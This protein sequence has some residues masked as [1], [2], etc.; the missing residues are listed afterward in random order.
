MTSNRWAKNVTMRLVRPR[1]LF[2]L[3]STNGDPIKKG[4]MKKARAEI[5]PSAAMEKRMS[6]FK[7]APL[8]KGFD[9]VFC[10]ITY[11]LSSLSCLEMVNS[12]CGR[13]RRS[14]LGSSR[15]DRCTV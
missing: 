9:E 12:F 15:V 8:S 5:A 11:V 1:I 3:K 2:V 14:G 13:K 10:L 6:F 4:K 7:I